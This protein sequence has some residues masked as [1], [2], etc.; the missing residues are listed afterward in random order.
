[1]EKYMSHKGYD[2][3]QILDA[4]MVWRVKYEND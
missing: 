3:Q 1:M 4:I 2:L